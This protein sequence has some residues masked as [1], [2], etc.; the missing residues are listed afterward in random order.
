MS[1]ANFKW[2]SVWSIAL[3]A[4]GSVYANG[5]FYVDDG[6]LF[7]RSIARFSGENGL[8][9]KDWQPT[10]YGYRHYSL[11]TTSDRLYIGSDDAS[12]C[13]QTLTAFAT[14]LPDRL[15]AADFEAPWY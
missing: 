4:N 8:A 10:P 7:E 5:Y 15:F 9:D 12:I 2:E 6:S 1:A 3:D 11:A 13:G 14:T